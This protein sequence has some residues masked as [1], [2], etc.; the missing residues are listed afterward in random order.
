[1]VALTGSGDAYPCHLLMLPEFRAD[2]SSLIDSPAEVRRQLK[3][4][5]RDSNGEYASRMC[6]KYLQLSPSWHLP[7][8]ESIPV[9]EA[10]DVRYFCGGGCRA[11][12]YAAT[13]DIAGRD[14]S[15]ESY[16]ALIS[17]L[18][19]AWDDRIPVIYNLHQACHRLGLDPS[20]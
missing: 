11:A 17:S 6:N 12:A 10:C 16:R 4:D 14:P 5:A 18:L 15:C 2:L 1:V 8:V 7:G 13:G 20:P 9:C 3:N 19:W